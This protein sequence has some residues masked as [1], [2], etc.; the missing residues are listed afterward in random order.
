MPKARHGK[1]VMARTTSKVGE[2][3]EFSEVVGENGVTILAISAWVEDA[4]GVCPALSAKRHHE[5]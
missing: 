4:V 1:G 3:A 2:L 5:R